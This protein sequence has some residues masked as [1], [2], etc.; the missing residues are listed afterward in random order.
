MTNEEK[1]K[2]EQ[3]RINASISIL[4]SLLEQTAHAVIEE[5]VVKNTYARVAISY[6]D[7][8]IR[9]LNR[10]KDWLQKIIEI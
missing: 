8:L 9:E 2:W 3:V 6:A 10:D 7:E 1:D 5:T 4:N